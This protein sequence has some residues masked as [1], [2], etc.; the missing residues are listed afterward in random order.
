MFTK[1][2]VSPK[3]YGFNKFKLISNILYFVII[4]SNMQASR[5]FARFVLCHEKAAFL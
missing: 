2:L 3:L 1:G 4:L 5:L